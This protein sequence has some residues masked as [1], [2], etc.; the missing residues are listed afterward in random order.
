MSSPLPGADYLRPPKRSGT[1]EDVLAGL[2]KHLDETLGKPCTIESKD[3]RMARKLDDL[4][5]SR[6]WQDNY[7]ASFFPSWQVVGPVQPNEFTDERM[8]KYRGRFGHVRND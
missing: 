6:V 7:N 8:R 4:W 5:S 3:A 2:F 1:K